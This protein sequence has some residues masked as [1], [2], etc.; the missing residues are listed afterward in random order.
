MHKT[1]HLGQVIDLRTLSLL[2]A[3]YAQRFA[4][5]LLILDFEYFQHYFNKIDLNSNT[6]TINMR[7]NY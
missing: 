6:N 2:P 1:E 3:I 4:L 5:L 7:I